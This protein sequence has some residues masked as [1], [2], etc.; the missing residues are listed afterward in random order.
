MVVVSRQMLVVQNVDGDRFVKQ[1][2]V[3]TG[4]KSGSL[5]KDLHWFIIRTYIVSER[6]KKF[7]KLQVV[8]GC[9]G[10]VAD[11]FVLLIKN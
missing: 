4:W 3:L 8:K 2:I 7:S 6:L 10:L 5:E 9:A 1:L 11:A